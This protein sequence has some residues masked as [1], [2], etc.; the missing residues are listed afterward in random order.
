MCGENIA[1][2]QQPQIT[3]SAKKRKL[4][5]KKLVET[6]KRVSRQLF[7]ESIPSTS[8]ITPAKPVLPDIQ[9]E[10]SPSGY[11]TIEPIKQTVDASVQVRVAARNASTQTGYTLMK[12]SGQ[13]SPS[14]TSTSDSPAP[15]SSDYTPT[16]SLTKSASIDFAVPHV[17]RM[18]QTAGFIWVYL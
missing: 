10:D 5:A 15:E 3:G 1:V 8:S 6:H 11:F 4:E 12:K 13:C 18:E 16:K 2:P 7:V 9:L 14:S 17:S